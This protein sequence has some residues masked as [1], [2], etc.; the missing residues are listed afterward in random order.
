MNQIPESIDECIE[1]ITS[2]VR[3]LLCERREKLI[4]AWQE[5]IN[6]ALE[7]DPESKIPHL[8]IGISAAIDINEHPARVTTQISFAARYVSK[9]SEQMDDKNQLKI[10]FPPCKQNEE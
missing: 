6:D 9:M 2:H 8:K 4:E 1:K 3:E 5:S 10:E 7:E